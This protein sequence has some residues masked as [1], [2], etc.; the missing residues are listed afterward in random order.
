VNTIELR[1]K[2]AGLIKEARAG[3]EVAGKREE[4]PTS[5]DKAL[6]DKLMVASN[7]VKDEYER[8]ERL[9]TAEGELSRVEQRVGRPINLGAAGD[10]PPKFADYR[11][12]LKSA[13]YRAVFSDWMRNGASGGSTLS[14][15]P[16]EYRDSILGTDG[17][18]GYLSLPTQLA[19]T[20]IKQCFDL[21]FI[22]QLGTVITLG[23][24]KA[25]GI[26]QLGTRMADASWTT[27][28]QA[29]TEDTT[30]AFT[31]RDLSP[32]LFPSWPRPRF[33]CSTEQ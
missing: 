21:L 11:D 8:M 12:Y 14:G 6:F 16:A 15:I 20:I 3:W 26:P 28:V 32:N 31:R 23:E 5:E 2:R 4:G 27:E 19:N 24:A 29:V 25:L 18:G 9:E 17:K 33:G 7:E 13:Q 30:Q 1:E 22:R 10:P